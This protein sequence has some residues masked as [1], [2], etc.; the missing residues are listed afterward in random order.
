MKF[1]KTKIQREK[2]RLFDQLAAI[3]QSL[4]MLNAAGGKG[5]FRLDAKQYEAK[6]GDLRQPSQVVDYVTRDS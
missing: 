1:A 6:V 4:T 5:A 2:F 3:D